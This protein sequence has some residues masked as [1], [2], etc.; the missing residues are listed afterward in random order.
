[1]TTPRHVGLSIEPDDEA[2]KRLVLKVGVSRHVSVLEP[3]EVVFDQ[4]GRYS[5]RMY[6]LDRWVEHLERLDA[7]DGGI[8]MLPYYFADQCTAWLRIVSP[9]GVVA[10]VQAGWSLL[11]EFEFDA[12]TFAGEGITVAD[13]EPIPNARIVRP[14]E[15]VIEAVVLSRKHLSQLRDLQ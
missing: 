6:M 10:E 3:D 8:V 7:A 9:D 13:F 1:L 14:L 15:D 12:E 11:S 4:G 2:G 5:T